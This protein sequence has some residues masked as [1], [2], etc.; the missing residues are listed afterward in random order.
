[1]G[2]NKNLDYLSSYFKNHFKSLYSS[3]YLCEYPIENQLQQSCHATGCENGGVCSSL[4]FKCEC[5]TNYTGKFD[6][7][8]KSDPNNKLEPF[9]KKEVDASL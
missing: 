8:I 5:L 2:L 9:K 6:S 4:S 3:G 1:M 7:I